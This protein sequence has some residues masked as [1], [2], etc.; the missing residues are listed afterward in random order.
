[1]ITKLNREGP[2]IKILR[3][4]TN[5]STPIGIGHNKGTF[6]LSGNLSFFIFRSLEHAPFC[7]TKKSNTFV[8]DFCI[9][10]V[11]VKSSNFFEESFGLVNATERIPNLTS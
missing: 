9:V 3:L 1:M 5:L 2:L 6:S 11:Y 8:M 7:K 10:G 4:I